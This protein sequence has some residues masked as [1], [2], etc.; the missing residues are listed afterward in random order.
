LRCFTERN[1][2]AA[3]IRKLRGGINRVKKPPLLYIVLTF[4]VNPITCPGKKTNINR[5]K[6]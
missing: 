3:Y 6:I 5:T 2:Y 1:L 4:A